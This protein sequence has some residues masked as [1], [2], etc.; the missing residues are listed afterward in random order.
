MRSKYVFFL[1]W[2]PLFGICYINKRTSLIDW[3]ID[4]WGN[5][6]IGFKSAIKTRSGSVCGRGLISSFFSLWRKSLT[7]FC[8]SS[9]TLQEDKPGCHWRPRCETKCT[10]PTA[11][12]R[13]AAQ[14]Q[15]TCYL[16]PCWID[17]GS[18]CVEVCIRLE[19]RGQW[20]GLL[21][22]AS[23]FEGVEAVIRGSGRSLINK[24]DPV[25]LKTLKHCC[26]SYHDAYATGV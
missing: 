15:I 5:R 12:C 13:K 16:T 8:V 10:L 2:K 26:P 22:S 7:R 1:I 18:A 17:G 20:V 23:S 11:T 4:R 19:V 6:L 25:T 14:E 24:L 21:L 3:L 9:I